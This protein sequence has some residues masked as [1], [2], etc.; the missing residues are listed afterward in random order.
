MLYILVFVCA[1]AG[2]YLGASFARRKPVQEVIKTP[3]SYIAK[4]AFPNR[5]TAP[6]DIS[7]YYNEY[8]YGPEEVTPDG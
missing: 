1:L 2:S 6:E 3:V 5:D 8:L 7:K 4:N